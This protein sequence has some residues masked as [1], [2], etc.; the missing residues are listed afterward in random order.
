M[1]LTSIA[2]C[3]DLA[4]AYQPLLLFQI[5][6][7][8]GTVLRMSSLDFRASTTGITYDG[9]DWFAEIMNQEIAAVQALSADGIDGVPSVNLK[10]YDADRFL[11][12]NYELGLGFKGATMVL[13]FVFFDIA[14]YN[15]TGAITFSS[16]Y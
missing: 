4:Q 2:A 9:H 11:F 3:K 16:D 13:K 8:D 14:G 10:L 12:T 7:S 1:P 5:T 6:F 15:A